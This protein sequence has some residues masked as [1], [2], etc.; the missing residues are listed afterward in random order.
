[1]SYEIKFTE[2]DDEGQSEL[3]VWH[4]GKLISEHRDGGEPED[5]YYFRDWDWVAGAL[6][7]AYN[8]GILD[9]EKLQ[10]A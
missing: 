7:Q 3:Q 5:R 2:Q 9:A 1:M 4:N 8:F 6:T 10:E